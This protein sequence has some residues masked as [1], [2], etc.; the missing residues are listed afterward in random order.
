MFWLVYFPA[1]I[2]GAERN[3]QWDIARLSFPR[4]S[5]LSLPSLPQTQESLQRRQRISRYIECGFG[6]VTGVY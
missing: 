2:M 1:Q 5:P 6:H 3:I 4:P